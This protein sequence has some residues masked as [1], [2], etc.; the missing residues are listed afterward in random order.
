MSVAAIDK[1]GMKQWYSNYGGVHIA[2]PAGV[3]T[4]DMMGT[5]SQSYP[6]GYTSGY[7]FCADHYLKLPFNTDSGFGGTSAAAPH[8]SAVAALVAWRFPALSPYSIKLR[9]MNRGKPPLQGSGLS[10]RYLDAF[11]TLSN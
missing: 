7:C 11:N 4:T 6:L 8:V 3:T 1:Y 9:I 5:N 2:A 10:C